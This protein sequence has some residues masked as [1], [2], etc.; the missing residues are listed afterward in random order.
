M[1]FIKNKWDDV[2]DPDCSK[3]YS[4]LNEAD[5]LKILINTSKV[6]GSKV[7]DNKVSEYNNNDTTYNDIQKNIRMGIENISNRTITRSINGMYDI[8]QQFNTFDWNDDKKKINQFVINSMNEFDNEIMNFSN[9]DI[10]V[11]EVSSGSASRS[12]QQA[13]IPYDSDDKA[14]PAANTAAPHPKSSPKPKSSA[15]STPSNSSNNKLNNL[16]K[17]QLKV[18]KDL[19]FN[20]LKDEV[21]D[22]L[23]NFLIN[24]NKEVF[25]NNDESSEDPQNA[26]EPVG[27][28]QD[29][30][31]SGQGASVSG[32]GASASAARDNNTPNVD[33]SEG[34]RCITSSIESGNLPGSFEGYEYGK[35]YSDLLKICRKFKGDTSGTSVNMKF[36]KRLRF[37]NG[38]FIY[39][40]SID[41]IFNKYIPPGQNGTSAQASNPNKSPELTDADLSEILKIPKIIEMIIN[42]LNYIIKQIEI[43]SLSR[44]I[45]Y[46]AVKQYDANTTPAV[47]NG[48]TSSASSGKD[49]EDTE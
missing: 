30:L 48:S 16:F 5:Y 15:N 14:R 4:P 20:T 37:T 27:H 35:E 41:K 3:V 43:N 6:I 46:L 47:G 28:T 13:P 31:A 40:D 8:L 32:Q 26:D 12:V 36:S 21:G 34:Y 7:L 39:L 22:L 44:H 18:K 1:S 29:S 45:V 42:I 24:Y 49:E 17:S 23:H 25:G 38:V 19:F 2:I 11:S 9:N 33:P 10:D